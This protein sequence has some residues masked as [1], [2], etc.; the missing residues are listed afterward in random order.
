[1]APDAVGEEHE[2]DV[3]AG[4]R[5]GEQKR[6][7]LLGAGLSAHEKANARHHERVLEQP[8]PRKPK[9]APPHQHEPHDKRNQR[10][11]QHLVDRAHRL[12]QLALAPVG[13][14]Q[15]HAQQKRV[16]EE[17]GQH[18]RHAAPQRIPLVQRV[19]ARGLARP[20]PGAPAL[21]EPRHGLP[22]GEHRQGRHEQVDHARDGRIQIPHRKRQRAR[23][24]QPARR[25]EKRLAGPEPFKEEHPDDLAPDKPHAA[26]HHAQRLEIGRVEEEVDQVQHA[27]GRHQH[28]TRPHEHAPRR[29]REAVPAREQHEQR[30]HGHAGNVRAHRHHAHIRREVQVV[31]AELVPEAIEPDPEEGEAQTREER[32]LERRERAGMK[33]PV[34]SGHASAVSP[35]LPLDHG[36]IIS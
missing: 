5:I 32:R 7:R 24:R 17:R 28:E 2:G 10:H 21:V 11:D 19:R 26:H 20:L 27:R 9:R 15:R 33:I 14:P 3:E 36:E 6:A 13:I 35:F 29:P 22:V 34:D 12:R 23:E 8:V 4:H 25:V 1:M 30:D 31:E 16:Q 18:L